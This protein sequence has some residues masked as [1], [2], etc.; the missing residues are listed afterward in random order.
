MVIKAMNDA[1]HQVIFSENDSPVNVHST[2]LTQACK[3][4]LSE[5]FEGRRTTFDLPL[6]QQGTA[7][8]QSVWQMLRS[9]AY[10][11]TITYLQLANKMG[12]DKMIRAVAN[13][14]GKNE[15][16]IIIP[17]HR[18]IGSNGSLTGYAWGLKRKQWLLDF[19][20]KTS[21]KKLSLF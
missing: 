14:N 21:G 1:I 10:G 19:E 20:A 13:A 18:V 8:Q 12:D 3:E 7:F 9:V 2:S 16:G 5:Y 15:L 11:D 4:Q 6:S 17:C